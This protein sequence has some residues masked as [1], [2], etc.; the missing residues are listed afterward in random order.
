MDLFLIEI[1]G[2]NVVYWYHWLEKL[3][4]NVSNYEALTMKFN[5]GGRN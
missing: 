2:F 1:V 5:M 3:E 4:D